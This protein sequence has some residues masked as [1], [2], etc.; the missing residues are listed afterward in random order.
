MT[1]SADRIAI[2][3]TTKK[4]SSPSA[5][6]MSL[7]E[8]DH[9]AR[10]DDVGERE[11]QQHLPAEAHE[12]VVAEARQRPADEDLQPA[13]EKHLGEEGHDLADD[14]HE[15]RQR[16]RPTPGKREALTVNERTLPAAEKHR[17]HE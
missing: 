15:V 6:V 9:H 17:H 13:E 11:R 4:V 14:D 10:K 3:A 2:A 12:L 16:E 8:Q 7:G 1:A 5:I